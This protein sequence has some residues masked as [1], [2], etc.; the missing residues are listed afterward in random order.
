MYQYEEIYLK[1]FTSPTK[2]LSQVRLI[3]F[4]NLT[5]HDNDYYLGFGALWIRR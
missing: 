2:L 5:H 3:K 4:S 1:I